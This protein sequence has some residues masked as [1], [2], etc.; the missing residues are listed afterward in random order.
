[1]RVNA[2]DNSWQEPEWLTAS[3]LSAS[4]SGETERLASFRYSELRH[5]SESECRATTQRPRMNPLVATLARVR[6]ESR[7][8]SC[9]GERGYRTFIAEQ[10]GTGVA[11]RRIAF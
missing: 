7:E 11:R 1:M 8:N 9:S 2:L 6:G 3:V 4:I 5:E 10:L